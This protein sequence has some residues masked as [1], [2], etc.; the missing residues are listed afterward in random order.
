[1]C[2]RRSAGRLGS[3][4]TTRV[5]HLRWSGPPSG[6]PTGPSS[7]RFGLAAACAGVLFAGLVPA[8]AQ[9]APQPYT[10]SFDGTTTTITGTAG[11]D[12]ISVSTTYDGE[13]SVY[14]AEPGPG[15]VR[16]WPDDPEQSATRCPLGDGGI[17]VHAL[18]GDDSVNGTTSGTP[19]PASKF[20]IELGDGN[21]RFSASKVD[22]AVTVNGGQGND[23]I[24]G[25][26]QDDVLDGGPGNDLV[27]GYWGVDVVRGGDGNDTVTGDGSTDNRSPDVI[28][29]GAGIDSTEDWGDSERA[30][31]VS[32]DG[33]ANDGYEGEGDAVT[34]VENVNAGGGLTF[35]G[36]DARNVVRAGEVATASASLLGLGGDDELTGT[37]R[38]DR[39][40]GGAGN[41]LI[42]GGYGNDTI[43]GGAGADDINGDRA[44]RC[45]EY[46]CDL[47]PGSAADII[48]A[49]DGEKD[50]VKCG[51]GTDT[52][53]ADAIDTVD[54]DCENVTRVG[55]GPNG[56]SSG[57]NGT[58][59]TTG[60]N[61]TGPGTT[62]GGGAQSGPFSLTSTKLG[63]ALKS[64]LKLKIAGQ[65][66]G[67][68]LSV[69]AKQ[70]KST[71]AKGSA[72]VGKSG[73]AT[74]TLKF[75]KAAKKKLKKAKTVTLSLNA[76]K[77]RQQ[78]TLTR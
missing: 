23:T 9:A 39:I 28:D 62:N 66:T 43:I 26:R 70:G 53:R 41:D 29:G 46:H 19:L 69:S 75:T 36:D 33:A 65:K 24:D 30:S 45:N 60:G 78:V 14:H 34:S 64:G 44:G 15:C 74:I 8:G 68:K 49:V 73:T 22:G 1:M 13:V 2:A 5:P 54:A 18:G 63:S 35:V 6:R 57:P 72:K 59:G 16:V 77:L 71:V 55:A 17:V 38:A 21:D 4:L 25:S 61:G 40:D 56:G 11:K 32:L 7:R 37:D 31:W 58:G 12:D 47:S 42:A 48:D 27:E 76:G 67:K 50:T 51:P 10:A 3:M 52:L 20:R